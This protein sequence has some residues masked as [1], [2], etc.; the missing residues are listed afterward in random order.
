MNLV[1]V[2]A[3]ILGKKVMCRLCGQVGGNRPVRGTGG[4]EDTPNGSVYTSPKRRGTHLLHSAINPK[5]IIN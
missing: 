4:R 1:H 2:S 3:D 5:K